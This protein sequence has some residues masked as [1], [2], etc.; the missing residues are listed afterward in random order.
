MILKALIGVEPSVVAAHRRLLSAGAQKGACFEMLGFDVLIDEALKPWLLEVNLSPALSA[1][2]PL[3]LKI[4]SC[5]LADL[6]TLVGVRPY[7]RAVTRAREKLERSVRLERL[8]RGEPTAVRAGLGPSGSGSARPGSAALG[9]TPREEASKRAVREMDEEEQRAGGWRRVFPTADG[10]GYL[11]LFAHPR[12]SNAVLVRELEARARTARAGV[13][14]SGAAQSGATASGLAQRTSA[15]RASRAAA[16][17]TDLASAAEGDVGG[18]ACG[19]VDGAGAAPQSRVERAVRSALAQDQALLAPMRAAMERGDAEVPLLAGLAGDFALQ[20]G[21]RSNPMPNHQPY[22]AS[23]P[24][25]RGEARAGGRRGAAAA[26]RAAGAATDEETSGDGDYSGESDGDQTDEG[27]AAQRTSKQRV[28]AGVEGATMAA[29][30]AAALGG[31]R[32][33]PNASREQLDRLRGAGTATIGGSALGAVSA[34]HPPREPARAAQPRPWSAAQSLSSAYR[35]G[36]AQRPRSGAPTDSRGVSH[37]E[38]AR[39]EARAMGGGP[40]P[41][42]AYESAW[43]KESVL[44]PPAPQPSHLVGSYLGASAIADSY[45]GGGGYPTDRARPRPV[46][47]SSRQGGLA[48]RSVALIADAE[49][50][51]LAPYTYT[52]AAYAMPRA[53]SRGSRVGAPGWA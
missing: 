25:E 47:A 18:R 1:D 9:R 45:L 49:R 35:S 41:P 32:L 10:A 39:A 31:G 16:A 50:E 53:G 20:P 30:L 3:D 27:G 40:P 37:V 51:R 48:S 28:S 5:M 24:E 19:A 23:L 12:P 6:F 52:A 42:A 44:R 8:T 26:A 36:A 13:A 34:R 21:I 29:A 2:A 43:S 15:S 46:S 17:A 4:K 11:P 7:D 22:G 33:L 38:V 14:A